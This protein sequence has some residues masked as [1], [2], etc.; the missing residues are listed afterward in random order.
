MTTRGLFTVARAKRIPLTF[1]EILDRANVPAYETEFR[2]DPVRR[3]RFDY[4]WPLVKIAVEIEGG[5][6][7]RLIVVGH[8]VERRKGANVAITPGTRIRVGGRHQTGP[9]MEA[10]IV[11]YNAAAVAGWLVLRATTTQVRDGYALAT[12]RAAFAARGLE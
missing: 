7:G 1:G 5:A 10:D 4:A 2:F 6:H 9:G 8:G 12:L 3:W 11:K